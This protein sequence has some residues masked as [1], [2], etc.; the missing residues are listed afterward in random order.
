MK[1]ERA[2]GV[3]ANCKKSYLICI[4]CPQDEGKSKLENYSIIII[5]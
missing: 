4:V 5:Y 2:C 3:L 1:A